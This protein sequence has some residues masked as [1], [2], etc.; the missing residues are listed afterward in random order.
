MVVYRN[1]LEAWFWTEGFWQVPLF[2]AVLFI[3][4]LAWMRLYQI[5]FPTRW[6]IKIELERLEA[7]RAPGHMIDDAEKRFRAIGW[8]LFR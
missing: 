1:P 6:R 7:I 8:K 2:I 3:G 5:M 4:F